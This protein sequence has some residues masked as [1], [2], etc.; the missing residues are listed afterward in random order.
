MP[1]RKQMT[2][3]QSQV[4]NMYAA[5]GPTRSIKALLALCTEDDMNITERMLRRWSDQFRWNEMVQQVNDDVVEKMSTAL[6]PQMLDITNQ[7]INA[8][9]TIQKRFIERLEIDPANPN[10]TDEERAR[11][12][13]PGLRDF[14]D[15]VK[16]ERLLLGDPTERTEHVATSRVVAEIS[17]PELQVMARELLARKY[18]LPSVK[19]IT[20]K[21]DE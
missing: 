2:P 15:A 1:A 17:Q 10:L 13:D 21:E 6:A 7:Q 19:N 4:F 16:L 3:V 5:I 18:G 8:L 14:A 9:H 20:P 11:A 12:I